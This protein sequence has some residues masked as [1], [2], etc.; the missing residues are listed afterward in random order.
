MSISRAAELSCDIY[1]HKHRILKT[2]RNKYIKV[3]EKHEHPILL[4]M[5]EGS[6]LYV[7]FRG[8]KDVREFIKCID[9][10]LVRPTSKM[11]VKIKKAFWETYNEMKDEL[12]Y[13]ISSDDMKDIN[14]V[15][16]TGHSKGGAIAQIAS[17]ML[18]TEQ[19]TGK[20]KRCITFG[21]PYVGDKGFQELMKH[22]TDEHKRVVAAGDIIPLA[23][24][25]KD[26]VHNGETLL[27]QTT[28][29]SPL[30]CVDHHSCQNYIEI[31][32]KYEELKHSSFMKQS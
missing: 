8:C 28:V 13:L 23:K 9:A 4:T 30:N 17:T 29:K 15:I 5:R 19:F 10:T 16:F 14:N 27:L 18:D 31:A 6:D 12:E 24:L 2:H 21:A 1:K 3:V 20:N 25:H 26:L 32:K 22:T 11:D 7:T